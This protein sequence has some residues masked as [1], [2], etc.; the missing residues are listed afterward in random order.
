MESIFWHDPD[1]VP[2]PAGTH[3]PDRCCFT[4]HFGLCRSKEDPIIFDKVVVAV[5]NVHR[6]LKEWGLKR[7]RFPLFVFLAVAGA[8]AVGERFILC[9]DVGNGETQVCV[10]RW[11]T[12][13][14]SGVRRL[15]IW[16]H[17]NRVASTSRF[18][19]FRKSH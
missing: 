5:T 16:I 8:E 3:V 4:R 14:Q 18:F 11:P 2:N 6:S 12:R 13:L 19:V 7:D 1:E 10:L 15:T 9:D 17:V